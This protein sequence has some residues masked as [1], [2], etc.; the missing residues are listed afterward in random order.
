MLDHDMDIMKEAGDYLMITEDKVSQDVNQAVAKADV[1]IRKDYLSVL[2]HAEVLPL[3]DKA[4]QIVPG[5]NMRLVKIDSFVFDREKSITKKIRNIYGSVAQ[6]KTGATLILNGKKDAV[7]IYLGVC[8]EKETDTA[9]SISSFL[10]AFNGTFPGSQYKNVKQNAVSDILEDIFPAEEDVCIA[11]LSGVTGEMSNNCENTQEKLDVLIDGMRGR[12]FSMILLAERMSGDE[13]IMMR[14]GLEALHTQISPF[15][16]IDISMTQGETDNYGYNISRNITHTLTTSSSKSHGYTK[17]TGKAK[18]VQHGN[19]N[20]EAEKYQAGK[21]ILGAVLAVGA[22]AIAGPAGG[23]AAEMTVNA[24]K[25]LQSLFYGQSLSKLLMD[26]DKLTENKTSVPK[27]IVSE[28]EHTDESINDVEQIGE[29]EAD[30]KGEGEGYSEGKAIN[31]GKTMQ[32]SFQNKSITNLLSN[33]DRQ[34]NNLERLE[35][36]GAFRIGAYFIAGDED[37]ATSAVN[38]YRSIVDSS[39]RSTDSAAVCKWA[40]G[41]KVR[42]ILEYLR[43]GFHPEFSFGPNSDFPVVM[44]AQPVSVSDIPSYFCLPESSLPG[45]DVTEHAAFA[46]DVLYKKRSKIKEDRRYADIGCIQHMGKE[47][48]F[49]RV[50]LD[51]DVLT[52]HMLVAG[53]TGMGKSNFCY[54]LIDEVTNLGIKVMIVEPAKGEYAKVFGGRSDFSVYGTNPNRS[55]LLKINPF[56][57]PEGIHVTEHIERLLAIF[58]AAW[59]MYSAMPAILRKAIEEIYLDR[60]FDMILGEKPENGEFPC[61]KDLL[62]KLPEIINKTEYSGEVKGNY[63]GALVMRVETLTKSVYGL[64]FGQEEIGDQGLF[65]ENVIID[66]SRAGSAETK[67]LLMGVLVMRLVEY[68][69]CSGEMNSPLKHLT[70]LEEAHNLLKKQT[71]G[72]AEGADMRAA[73]VEMI[74]DAIAEMRTYGQGFIIADQRPTLLDPAT[75][76]NTKT[77]VFFM[78]PRDDDR[79]VAAKSCSLNSRQQDEIGKL[80]IGEAVVYQ[81][82]W[83]QAVLSK[84]NYFPKEHECPYIHEKQNL[85]RKSKFAIGQAASYLLMG[86]MNSNQMSSFDA[87]LLKEHMESVNSMDVK[88]AKIVRNCFDAAITG[89]EASKELAQ[90]AGDLNTL[91]DFERAFSQCKNC[92]DIK[93]WTEKM[94]SIIKNN[95]GLTDEEV[96]MIVSIGLQSKMKGKPEMKKLYVKHL[97]FCIENLEK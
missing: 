9:A 76:A 21:Q 44:A 33:I 36:E 39:G 74:T 41:S 17:T 58:N 30:A 32:R 85:S 51:L 29:S 27:D 18:N 42:G 83:S 80:D 24:G 49:A 66:I 13:L 64:I 84:I 73:S 94:H 82:G 88:K 14:Q 54:Q 6:E 81:N 68:R 50:Q 90:I 1:F 22:T 11:T 63:I 43:R 5:R 65:D 86:R 10:N 61:F 59:P 79:T 15:Q 25:A 4:K 19:D 28:N 26:V 37:T 46:R 48:R 8:T 20:S 23:A 77:K 60:G 95:T 67:A 52:A 35:H 75:D 78:M 40:N 91:V 92:E 69:M 12:P 53:T 31:Q 56:A 2:N 45:L 47:D 87:D 55:P 71:L 7:D 62:E 72:T 70:L 97:A 16:K 38:L 3:S 96:R 89:K 57:Y 34:I 93:Q